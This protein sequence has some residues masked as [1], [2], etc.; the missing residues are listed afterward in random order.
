ME[1]DP[2]RAYLFRPAARAD[3]VAKGHELDDGDYC[4]PRVA[5][6]SG[7]GSCHGWLPALEAVGYIYHDHS[8]VI[9]G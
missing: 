7:L 1:T 4:L 5:E 9:D 6:P 3:A 2:D 8:F